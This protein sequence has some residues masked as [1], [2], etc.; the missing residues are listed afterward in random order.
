MHP[1]CG[2]ILERVVPAGGMSF[3]AGF[4]PGGTVVGINPWV[5]AQD[6]DVYGADAA[7]FRPERWSE[8]SAKQLR[9]MERSFL[10]VSL[11]CLFDVHRCVL[12]R[13]RSLDQAGGRAWGRIS[14]CWR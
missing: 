2:Q 5:V 3:A 13:I 4:L 7:V 1:S 9:L 8:A 14:Q 10:A 6:K 12:I 11:Y